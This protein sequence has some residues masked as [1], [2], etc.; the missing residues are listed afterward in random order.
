[1]N[2]L[3]EILRFKWPAELTLYGH[4]IMKS[5]LKS[6]Q[7]PSVIAISITILLLIAGCASTPNDQVDLMPA[8]D[9]YGDG[10]INPL[11]QK[12]PLVE[13]HR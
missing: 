1:M 10:L 2:N 3:F 5:S 8:P 12:D 13:G 6:A 9:V 7:T 4:G 11:P